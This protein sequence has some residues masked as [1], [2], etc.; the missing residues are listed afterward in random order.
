ML[1]NVRDASNGVLPLDSELGEVLTIQIGEA[2]TVRGVDIEVEHRPA[3]A[4]A[5]R[6]SRKTTDDLG[7]TADFF[8]RSL[9]QVRRAEPLAEARK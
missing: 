8:E 9:E 4:Q 1:G 6:L 2:E 3:Q 7:P 5:A